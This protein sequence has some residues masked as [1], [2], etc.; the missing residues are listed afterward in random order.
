VAALEPPLEPAVDICPHALERDAAARRDD[1]R[2]QWRF[3]PSQ[4][5]RH[6][7]VDVALGE[8]EVVAHDAVAG[9][10]QAGLEVRQV[11]AAAA[12]PGLCGHALAP[13]LGGAAGGGARRRPLGPRTRAI[14]GRARARAM[15]THDRRAPGG[16]AATRSARHA[17][18]VIPAG[19]SVWT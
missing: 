15:P 2:N 6:A 18:I 4:V 8:A 10:R 13:G 17:R 5:L 9:H 16:S 19:M 3:L 14:L 11:H 1:G 7:C 12:L